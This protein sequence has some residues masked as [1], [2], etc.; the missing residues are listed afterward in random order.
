MQTKL[1]FLPA[2]RPGLLLHFFFCLVHRLT[3]RDK[4]K[5]A[6]LQT[7]VLML[8]QIELIKPFQ[9]NFAEVLDYSDVFCRK[10]KTSIYII[11]RPE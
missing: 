7:C 8:S 1:K 6:V 3:V 2:P 4:I 11:Q 5:P 9:L 10:R